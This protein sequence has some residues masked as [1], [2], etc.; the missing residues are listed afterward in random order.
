MLFLL[1]KL[2]PIMRKCLPIFPN[3]LLQASGIHKFYWARI[4]FY[5][6]KE[7][8]G[9]LGNGI[10]FIVGSKGRLKGNL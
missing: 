1:K 9:Y 2:V 7:D 5:G 4:G 10:E 6:V 3:K 8:D